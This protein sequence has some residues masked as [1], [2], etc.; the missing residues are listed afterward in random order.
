MKITEKAAAIVE[1]KIRELGYELYD[2]EFNKEY[3]NWELLITVDGPNGITLDDCEAISRAIEPILDEADPIE[4]PYYLTVSSI[5]LDRPLK[6]SKDF[7]RN[8]GNMIDVKLYTAPADKALGGKKNFAAKLV[9]H[10]ETTFTIET[11]KGSF[12]LPKKA[13]ALLRPHIDF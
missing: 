4:Q 9:S 7:D 11:E 3:G 5:G 10:D 12:T 13:A 6:L 8:L 2:V 1:P